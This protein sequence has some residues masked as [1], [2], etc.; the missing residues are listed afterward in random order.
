M[1]IYKWKPY[2]TF[3]FDYVIAT[4]QFFPSNYL[5]R[6][7]P[8]DK[9][10]VRNKVRELYN[11]GWNYTKIHKYLLKNSYEISTHRTSIDCMIKK[12]NKGDEFLIQPILDDIEN[13][14]V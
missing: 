2:S 6:N 1:F 4:H 12:M 13:F 5:I 11:Q 8:K 7:I 14:R 3:D 10:P 9:Q